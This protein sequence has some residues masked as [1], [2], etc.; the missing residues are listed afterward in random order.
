M[1]RRG[2]W[3][4]AAGERS[5]CSLERILITLALIGHRIGKS[6]LRAARILGHGRRKAVKAVAVVLPATPPRLGRN[7]S[8]LNGSE[9][10]DLSC[11]ALARYD[12]VMTQS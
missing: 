4:G 12:Y 10:R 1:S 5:P 7:C 11:Q 2:R 9:P 3:E 6:W 8:Q